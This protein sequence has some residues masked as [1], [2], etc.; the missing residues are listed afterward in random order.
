MIHE[1]YVYALEMLEQNHEEH[2]LAATIPEEL[3]YL[4]LKLMAESGVLEKEEYA[5]LKEEW[6]QLNKKGK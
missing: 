5:D 3:C 4:N 2:P 1:F 6:I